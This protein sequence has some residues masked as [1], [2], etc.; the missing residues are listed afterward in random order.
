MKTA[1]K[2][3]LLFVFIGLYNFS[4]A[5]SKIKLGHI[6]S[7]ELL[8]MM[9][10][11]DSAEIKMKEY[12]KT[13]ETQYAAMN[14][15]LETKYNDLDANKATMSDLIK[16]MKQKEIEDLSKRIQEFQQSAQ[17]DVQKKEQELLKPIIEKA[18]KAIEDVAKENGYT[19]IFD[20]STQVLLYFENNDDI[21]PLVKKKLGLK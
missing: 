10:G 19:Y 12:A 18:R 2:L 13:L 17:E 16:Q 6:D 14:S 1:F 20:R 9:P 11:R 15:E 4:N 8:K 21:M 5:Q 3:V 7:G